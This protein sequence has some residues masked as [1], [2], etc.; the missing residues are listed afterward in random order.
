MS[1]LNVRLTKAD[2]AAVRI[3]KRSRVE[4]STVVREALRREADRHRPRTAASTIELLAEIFEQF[5]E[6][7]HVETRRLDPLDRRAVAKA[8][9]ARLR[10][11]RRRRK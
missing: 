4:V 5:P 7:D 1:L 2:E 10:R 9:R 3:L 6:P 11:R 8:V